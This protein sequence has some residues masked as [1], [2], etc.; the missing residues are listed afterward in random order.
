MTIIKELQKH[1]DEELKDSEKYIKC[2]INEK[3]THKDVADL[4]Y[5]LSQEE[6]GHAERLHKLVVDKIEEYKRT[7]GEPPSEMMFLY[8]FLHEIEI[9]KMKNIKVLQSMYK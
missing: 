7:N 3:E 6:M 9:D 8:N 2:A 5:L 4:Y 1:I